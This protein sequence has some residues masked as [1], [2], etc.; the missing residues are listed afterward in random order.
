MTPASEEREE[1]DLEALE[2]ELGD[3]END[4]I[5]LWSYETMR[6]LIDIAREAQLGA[7]ITLGMAVL[8][9]GK[10]MLVREVV[11]ELVRRRAQSEPVPS[12]DGLDALESTAL[13]LYSADKFGTGVE[14]IMLQW[15]VRAYGDPEAYEG[16]KNYYRRLARFAL[17][18]LN[19]ARPSSA[20]DTR[21]AR[22]EALEEAAKACDKLQF[23]A[24]ELSR[25][26]Q[27]MDPEG[28][29]RNATAA[30]SYARLSREIRALAQQDPPAKE[31]GAADLDATNHE[32]GAVGSDAPAQDRKLGS[33]VAALYNMSNDMIVNDEKRYD[34]HFL[35]RTAEAI[36]SLRARLEAVCK[37]A[38]PFLETLEHDIGEF[39]TE[40][41]RFEPMASGFNRAPLLLIGHFT[42]LSRAVQEAGGMSEQEE[43]YSGD[44]DDEDCWQCGGEGGY[45]S[46]CEDSC[47]SI[48]GEE[49]CDD[50]AC[51]RRCSVCHGKGHLGQRS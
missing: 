12:A 24:A 25:C 41:D 48:Y 9:D 4:D 44:E 15:P 34:P 6:A 33:C 22:R 19:R 5:P 21:R 29:A 36:A 32:A 16:E 31:A 49:G 17:A 18:G 23:E 2:N 46:C 42:A 43:Y 51:W 3:G 13:A 50:P 30:G 1:I 47:P 26:Y 11:A 7:E 38:G 8:V 35:S 27:R 37:A 20:Q 45:P 40:I 28:S 39:E 14:T 10:Q